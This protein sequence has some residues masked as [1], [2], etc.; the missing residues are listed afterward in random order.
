M[1][2]FAGP[3]LKLSILTVA[4]DAGL[5]P[6]LPAR[7]GLP[8]GINVSAINTIV[9]NPRN[10]VIFFMAVPVRARFEPAFF[11]LFS[12]E[13]VLRTTPATAVNQQSPANGC[14]ARNS[15]ARCPARCAIDRPGLS[16]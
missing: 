4:P 16:W 15:H 9:D 7:S 12:F 11:L 5:S 8:S 3:K 1:S 2:M 14:L 10:Q 13:T 6:A